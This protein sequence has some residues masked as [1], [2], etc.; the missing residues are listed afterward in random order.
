MTAN[1]LFTFSSSLENSIL[2]SDFPVTA[3]IKK[4]RV[5]VNTRVLFPTQYDVGESELPS[6]TLWVSVWDWDRFGKNKFLGEVRLPL[7][8]VDFSDSSEHWYQLHE[9]VQI[10]TYLLCNLVCM[11]VC[12]C[13]CV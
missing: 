1:L 11:C 6:R 13:V 10:V 3:Y 4:P 9:K 12:V 2:T 5:S 7:S 8:S